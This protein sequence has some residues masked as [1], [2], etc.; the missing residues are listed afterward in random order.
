M[1][2]NAYKS[3]PISIRYSIVREREEESEREYVAIDRPLIANSVPLGLES[4]IAPSAVTWQI[5]QSV[6]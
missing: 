5:S 4:N 3:G 1:A 2:P 6:S